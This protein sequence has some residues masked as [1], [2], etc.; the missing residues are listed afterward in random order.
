MT[1]LIKEEMSDFP[2]PRQPKHAPL[3]IKNRIEI[4]FDWFSELLY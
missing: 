4:M 1:R 2:L 3:S